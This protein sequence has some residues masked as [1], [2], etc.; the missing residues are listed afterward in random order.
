MSKKIFGYLILLV[1]GTGLVACGVTP[2]EVLLDVDKLRLEEAW[3]KAMKTAG[4]LNYISSQKDIENK[5]IHYNREEVDMGPQ[6]MDLH[7]QMEMD[8]TDPNRP[9]LTMQGEDQDVARDYDQVEDDMK[10]IAEYV[11][12]CCGVH[13]DKTDTVSIILEFDLETGEL[14]NIS[15]FNPT[16]TNV[17]P[18]RGNMGKVDATDQI[19]PGKIKDV[20]ELLK[21]QLKKQNPY[22]IKIGNRWYKI[23]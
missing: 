11:H 12:R 17:R 4:T 14:E 20:G 5:V 22:W 10:T 1:L 15:R 3:E 7:I 18:Y 9:V 6:P 23:G 2:R 19:P 21:L 8:L 13:E 16:P